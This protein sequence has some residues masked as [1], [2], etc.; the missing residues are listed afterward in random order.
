MYINVFGQMYGIKITSIP[1][2]INIY[3]SFLKTLG[4]FNGLIFR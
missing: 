2:V 1:V 3:L 4:M